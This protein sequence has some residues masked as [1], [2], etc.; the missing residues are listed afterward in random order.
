VTGNVRASWSRDTMGPVIRIRVGVFVAVMALPCALG[1]AWLGC[2]AGDEQVEG[3]PKRKL[4]PDT[5]IST[6][7]TGGGGGDTGGGGTDTAKPPLCTGEVGTPN[8]CASATDLGTIAVG[9]TQTVTN[10]LPEKGGDLWFKLQFE[11]LDNTSAHPHLVLT[12]TDAA[13]VLEVVKTC[14]GDTLGCGDEDAFAT[15]IKDFEAVYRADPDA[16]GTYTAGTDAF[17]PMTVGESGTVYVRVY[18]TTGTPSACDFKLDI[19]N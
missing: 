18:R 5:G 6:E 2:A 17:V 7:D 15:R 9:A 19:S 10:A 11:T 16:D 14:S 4:P 3:A 12:S 13:I 8:E 1:A